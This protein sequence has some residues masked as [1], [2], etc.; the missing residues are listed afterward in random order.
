MQHE[1]DALQR[2]PV[3]QPLTSR[4]PEVPLTMRQQRSITAHNSSLISH[5][6]RLATLDHPCAGCGHLVS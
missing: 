2:Q 6:F 4:M 5:G 1:Q 3:I